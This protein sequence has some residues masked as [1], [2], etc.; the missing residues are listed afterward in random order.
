MPR[1]T[2]VIDE[3]HVMSLKV[4]GL[5]KLCKKYK[6][7][8]QGRKA[9][10]Q[11]RI[12]EHLEL[13]KYA[14]VKK[15]EPIEEADL[16]LA[17]PKAESAP[18]EH[19]V[20]GEQDSEID[21]SE[22]SKDA[23]KL[24]HTPELEDQS[25]SEQ[26]LASGEEKTTT[27]SDVEKGSLPPAAEIVATNNDTKVEDLVDVVSEKVIEENENIPA[28][29][30]KAITK[31]VDEKVKYASEDRKV[32]TEASEQSVVV[33]E[34]VVMKNE[35]ISTGNKITVM[36]NSVGEQENHTTEIEILAGKVETEVDSS[37]KTSVVPEDIA[38]EKKIPA[39]DKA[40]AITTS[41]GGEGGVALEIEIVASKDAPKMEKSEQSVVVSG[42]DVEV[43]ANILAGNKRTASE[44]R[45]SDNDSNAIKKP[46]AAKNIETKELDQASTEITSKEGSEIAAGS[47][48]TSSEAGISDVTTTAK[49]PKTVE[50]KPSESKLDISST[51]RRLS[52]IE[53]IQIESQKPTTGDKSSHEPKHDHVPLGE[54]L[55]KKHEEVLPKEQHE[56][57]TSQKVE[58]KIQSDE[59]VSEAIVNSTETEMKIDAPVSKKVQPKKVEVNVPKAKLPEKPT[60]ATTNTKKK[61]RMLP[62]KKPI[63][64]TRKVE[65]EKK[66]EGDGRDGRL[67]KSNQDQKT[68]KKKKKN[69]QRRYQQEKGNERRDRNRNWN[70]NRG[71]RNNRN[72]NRN[73][74]YR[75]GY[76]QPRHRWP[77][78]DYLN[79]SDPRVRNSMPLQHRGWNS[80]TVWQQP[81]Y[82][83][84][85]YGNDR[86]QRGNWRDRDRRD[87]SWSNNRGRRRGRR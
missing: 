85:G 11:D 56:E 34:D 2:K 80:H 33:P 58:S 44:S 47:K 3:K 81:S 35:T 79:E 87:M 66:N 6:L 84:G 77:H 76:A 59:T 23:G 60:I 17:Q 27:T 42:D 55:Q 28:G 24:K 29:G 39:Q 61:K 26:K 19:K 9:V 8:Q 71:N 82:Y 74:Y 83:L 15:A 50:Q 1:K 53:P 32:E 16:E 31:A 36:T 25:K 73:D 20:Q 69:P 86:M 41:V 49:K 38:E 64:H 14:D 67:S 57:N 45:I 65:E 52:E 63:S 12:L 78:A 72:S 75:S 54:N 46:K 21:T 48:R 5:K 10:L 68:A 51:S 43:N 37:E 62:F 18:K 7:K 4:V 70:R 40:T 13:G 22:A 30:K